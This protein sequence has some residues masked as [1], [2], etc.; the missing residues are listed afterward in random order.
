MV[1]YRLRNAR[2]I[3]KANVGDLVAFYL[4][5]RAYATSRAQGGGLP[6]P[7]ERVVSTYTRRIRGTIRNVLVC[8]C[9]R[10]SNRFSRYFRCA[11]ITYF[12]L[13]QRVPIALNLWPVLLSYITL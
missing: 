6:L 3:T 11:N 5:V 9:S 2:A 8:V 4:Y 12:H 13:I 7:E 1:V 10:K